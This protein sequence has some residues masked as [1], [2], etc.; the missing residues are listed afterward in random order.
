MLYTSCHSH[1]ISLKFNIAVLINLLSFYFR[2]ISIIYALRIRI[3][4]QQNTRFNWNEWKC[5]RLRYTKSTIDWQTKLIL[6]KYLQFNIFLNEHLLWYRFT[7]QQSSAWSYNMT[8]A[9]KHSFVS[10]LG[11]WD[12]QNF[13]TL[14]FYGT[15]RYLSGLLLV[16]TGPGSVPKK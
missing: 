2:E 12:R 1:L 10:I 13:F 6:T 14:H 16:G 15:F 7:I 11:G 9:G 8:S 3:A 4:D 5:I